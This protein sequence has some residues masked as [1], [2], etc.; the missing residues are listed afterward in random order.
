MRSS[1]ADLNI[2]LVEDIAI[3]NEQRQDPMDR[4]FI[5]VN[6]ISLSNLINQMLAFKSK[7][8][9]FF[10]VD[11]DIDSLIKDSKKLSSQL[12]NDES[13]SD[14]KQLLSSPLLVYYRSFLTC[15][16]SEENLDFY[17][18]TLSYKQLSIQQEINE[19]AAFIYNTYLRSGAIRQVNIAHNT[20]QLL[21]MRMNKGPDFDLNV[22]E[23][24]SKEIYKL[25][26]SD[27]WKRFIKS[28]FFPRMHYRATKKEW[29]VQGE[30]TEFKTGGVFPKL[31][32]KKPKTRVR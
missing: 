5:Q 25:M 31:S 26:E 30:E 2:A 27:S 29:S 11:S 28:D 9:S 13:I 7:L 6:S 19:H 12:F 8:H 21:D 22:F 20:Q 4:C 16:H 24:A 3:F 17:L 23:K 15:E 32:E 1:I 10:P 14:L 18:E